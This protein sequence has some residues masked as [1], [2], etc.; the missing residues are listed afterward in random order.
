MIIISGSVVNVNTFI[1]DY[2]PNDIEKDIITKMDL[3]K[4]QYKYDSL[5]QFKFELDFRYSIVI[6]AKNLNKG[7][8]D[9]RTFRKSICNPDYWD[10]TKEGGFILKKGAAPSDAIK[11]ISINSSKYGTECA[12][13]MVIIYYQ[14]L[15]NIFSAN[16]FNRLFP[17]IQ[18][19]NWHYI[20]NLLEDVGFIKK[21]SDYFPGD[22]R[23]FYNPDVDPVTP[24][25]QGENVIDLSNGLYYGHGIGIGD[26][27]EIISELN[28]FRIKETT[29]SSY[30]LDSAARPDFKSLA[31][32]K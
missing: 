11:D 2:N 32:I 21:R 28:K 14:A 30:L 1:H 3:S 20:D 8:M 25:W 17:N 6:A 7:D 16:L 26:A 4:S 31:D 9:F 10:R 27:D 23:Y 19:M 18:L 24:E 15:L 12:T 5:N 29:T 13:A 22:R